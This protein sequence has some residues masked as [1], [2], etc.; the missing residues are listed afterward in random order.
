MKLLADNSS[1]PT[2]NYVLAN[3][4]G[5][6]AIPSILRKKSKTYGKKTR[7]KISYTNG[8]FI[9]EPVKM[10]TSSLKG[11]FPNLKSAQEIKDQIRKEDTA[12]PR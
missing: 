10:V 5:I 1:Y 3:K 11:T 9:L 8:Q 2:N 6:L 12:N 4:R 7:Y